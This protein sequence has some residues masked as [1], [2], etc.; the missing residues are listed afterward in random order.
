M[1][2]GHEVR[3]LLTAQTLPTAPDRDCGSVIASQPFAQLRLPDSGSSLAWNFPRLRAISAPSRPSTMSAGPASA[4]ERKAYGFKP[5]AR[6]APMA[7]N[8]PQ[9]LRRTP[10][11]HL[12][13]YFAFRSIA[14][15]VDWSAGQRAFL[16]SLRLAVEGLPDRERER[17]YQDLEMTEMLADEVGQLAIRSLFSE[18]APFVLAFERMD[19]S[20]ARTLAALAENEALFRRALVARLADRLRTGRSWSGFRVPP[21]AGAVSATGLASFEAD[22]RAI[23]KKLDGSGRQL[24]IDTFVR[25]RPGTSGRFTQYTVFIEGLPQASN[26]FEANRLVP[27]TRRPVFEAALCHDAAAGTIDVVCKGGRSVRL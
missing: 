1:K 2:C 10:R 20:E 9:F 27:R 16:D 19:N 26:E 4:I 17:V 6:I 14:L 7:F 3:M 13:S 23:F 22:L 12:R 24:S 25:D 8:L 5:G 11:P 15:A 18:D 21:T